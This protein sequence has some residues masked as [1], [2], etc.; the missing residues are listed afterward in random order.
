MR[1]SV[2]V[3]IVLLLLFSCS[4]E[5]STPDPKPTPSTSVNIYDFVRGKWTYCTKTPKDSFEFRKDTLILFWRQPG[6]T[7]D[8]AYLYKIEGGPG[9]YLVKR[10]FLSGDFAVD[11]ISME[12]KTDSSLW[13]IGNRCCKQ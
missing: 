11:T 13:L 7:H 3:F 4:K 8:R 10:T 1:H 12:I 5:E 9:N 2:L 6:E